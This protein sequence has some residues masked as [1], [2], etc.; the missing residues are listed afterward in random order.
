MKK[1]SCVHILCK[2]SHN[3][4]QVFC[5]ISKN[6]VIGAFFEKNLYVRYKTAIRLIFVIN[7]GED[8]RS[9]RKYVVI[10]AIHRTQGVS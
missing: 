8:N 2:N 7:V 1:N 10:T 4:L 3:L 5:D 6:E 9:D